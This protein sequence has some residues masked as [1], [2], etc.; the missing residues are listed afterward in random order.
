MTQ[1]EDGQT[2]VVAANAFPQG[3]QVSQVIF[4]QQSFAYKCCDQCKTIGL[5]HGFSLYVHFIPI[6]QGW[7]IDVEWLI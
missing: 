1:N 7:H 6:E 4:A 3:A 5:K 2:Q